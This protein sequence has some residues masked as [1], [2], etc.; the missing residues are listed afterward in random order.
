M[1]PSNP[2]GDVR[3]ADLEL[4]GRI[5]S[6]DGSAF[7][8]LY[9]QHAT[10]LYNLASRMIGT[11]GEADDLLQDIFLL[12]YRKLGSFRGESS[13]G[14]WLYRLAMNQ[15]LDHVRSRA[16]RTGQLTD[17]LDDTSL[18]AD[19]A[20]HRLADRAIDRIDLERRDVAFRDLELSQ[21]APRAHAARRLAIRLRGYGYGFERFAAGREEKYPGQNLYCD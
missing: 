1:A 9:R 6:G 7:E 2:S 21:G 13:L 18:L 19:A 11:H 5:K 20:G 8:A 10:R 14:T 16:A 4:V 12:A 3:N 15:I 17:G